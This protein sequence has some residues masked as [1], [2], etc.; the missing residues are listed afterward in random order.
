MG[1]LLGLFEEGVNLFGRYCE[2]GTGGRVG[3]CVHAGTGRAVEVAG[4]HTILYSPEAL[5]TLARRSAI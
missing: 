1:R 3:A 4:F 5:A 2:R